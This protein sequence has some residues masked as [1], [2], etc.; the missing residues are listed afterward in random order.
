M[1]SLYMGEFIVTILIRLILY[2][3]Y[4]TPTISPP[5]H[6]KQMQEVSLFYFI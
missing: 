3:S 5:P 2:I 6:L 4:I 1:Y